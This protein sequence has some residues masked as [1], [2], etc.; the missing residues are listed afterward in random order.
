[1]GSDRVLFEIPFKS[2]TETHKP[3]TLTVQTEHTEQMRERGEGEKK[4]KKR[5]LKDDK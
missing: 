1:M 4:E 5:K 3:C 2:D